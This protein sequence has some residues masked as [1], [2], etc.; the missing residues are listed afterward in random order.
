VCRKTS[1]NPFW[2][3][4]STSTTVCYSTN[5]EQMEKYK[6]HFRAREDSQTIMECRWNIELMETLGLVK[7]EL[8]EQYYRTPLLPISCIS[9]T[10]TKMTDFMFSPLL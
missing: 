7:P 4:P 3:V 5:L 2:P 6:D 9:K 8:K 1:G 10:I